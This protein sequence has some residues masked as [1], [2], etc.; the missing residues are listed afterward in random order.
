MSRL[1]PGLLL[2]VVFPALLLLSTCGESPL[3]GV[4]DWRYYGGDLSGNRYS[5]LDQINRSNVSQLQVAWTHQTGERRYSSPEGGQVHNP[6]TSA[7]DVTAGDKIFVTQCAACH[8]EDGKGGAG[9][10]ASDLTGKELKY[11][12]SDAALFAVTFEGIPSAGMPGLYASEDEVWQIVSF[13]RSL[14]GEDPSKQPESEGQ[15]RVGW[16]AGAR[17]ATIECTPIVVDGVMYIST[18]FT[19]VTVLDAATGQEIWTFDPYQDSRFRGYNRGVMYWADGE[20]KRIYF[21]AGDRLFAL[22]AG[23]GKPI[24]Q[25]GEQGSVDLNQGFDREV[26]YITVTSPGVIYKNLLILGS[27]TY[28]GLSAVGRELG[29][30]KHAPGHLR[31]FDIHTGKQVW[32]FYT[33][34]RP[35]EFGYETWPP[36]AWKEAYGAN[37]WGGLRLD[38]ERGLVFAGTAAAYYPPPRYGKNL[39]A[40]TVL[41]LKAETGERVWHFQVIHHD[42]WDLDIPC[43]ANLVTVEHNG[44]RID[45]LAQTGKHGMVF[46]LNR[47]TGEPLFP[48][49]E[50]PVSTTTDIEGE[51]LWPTQPFTVKPPPYSRHGLTKEDVTD[52]SPERGVPFFL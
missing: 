8:G 30:I 47:E 2:V 31:A 11:G 3:P 51:K 40:N 21:T 18:L 15:S 34:P 20:G 25:F 9:T 37:N 16:G 50:R 41:A 33:I 49:E 22:N 29:Q 26:N 13:V 23:S 48:V 6:R 39:F 32:I 44:R 35:G 28:A 14:R 42:V 36:D 1:L 46:L 17:W 5:A 24:I 38:R 52:V 27:S 43:P 7:E 45:A 19:K 12:S 4:R 10:F